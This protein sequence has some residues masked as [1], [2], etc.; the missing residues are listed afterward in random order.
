MTNEQ[1]EHLKFTYYGLQFVTSIFYLQTV[2]GFT[3]VFGTVPGFKIMPL[4]RY[5]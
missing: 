2:S 4:T 5:F 3:R 1:K